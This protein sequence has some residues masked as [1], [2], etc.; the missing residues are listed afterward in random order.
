MAEDDGA[1]F[2][3]AQL[4]VFLG[5]REVQLVLR[6]PD[7]TKL[8]EQV[9]NLLLPPADELTGESFGATPLDRI[10]E[11]LSAV[12]AVANLSPLAAQP[13]QPAPVQQQPQYQTAQQ[14]GWQ[15]KPQN[16]WGN[17][18]QAAPA[19]VRSCECG[20]MTFKTGIY[21]SGARAGQ[22]Y[23]LWKCPNDIKSHNVWG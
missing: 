13:V 17:Q 20:P 18:Q 15:G 19:G 6:A 21:K 8:A 22:P 4:S 10:A 2:P 23:T 7:P 11:G 1:G 5:G 9:D 3:G 16:T 12:K 14:G